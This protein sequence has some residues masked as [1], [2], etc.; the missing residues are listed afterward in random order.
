VARSEIERALGSEVAVLALT[1]VDFRTGELHDMAR[2]TAAAHA[3]GASVLWDLAHSAGSLPVDLGGCGAD[4]A[5]GCGYKYL[6][7]GPGAPAFAFVA[8]AHH[9]D[10][11]TPLAGWMGHRQP[12][13]F[14]AEYEAAAGVARLQ[15]GTPPILSLS[16]LHEALGVLSQVPV[17]SLRRKSVALSELFIA[18]VDER[19]AGHGFTLASPRDPARRGSHVAL[20]HRQAFAIMQALIANGVIGDFRAPDLLRFGFAA[21][22]NRFVDVWDAVATLAEIMASGEWDSPEHRRRARVT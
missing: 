19:L 10:L 8:R 2:M 18:L 21:A 5:V 16:A 11:Q 1:H 3:V 17:H 15:T 9:D 12:F 13:D 22:Y 6:N 4:F 20:A 7:G 14:S